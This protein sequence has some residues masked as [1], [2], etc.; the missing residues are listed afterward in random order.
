VQGWFISH[1][2]GLYHR[3]C[4]HHLT[5]A[6]LRAE[7]CIPFE[8]CSNELTNILKKHGDR[9]KQ[10]ERTTVPVIHRK[11]LEALTAAAKRK[12]MESHRKCAGFVHVMRFSPLY[13]S[14]VCPSVSPYI[15][16][17][18]NDADSQLN[19]VL[20]LSAFEALPKNK[21]AVVLVC[22]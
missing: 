9:T 14:P 2:K 3:L 4:C 19:Y 7:I 20:S 13:F 17:I 21:S 15:S 10:A 12:A 5:K 18:S 22:L 6:S 16:T 1:S 11:K 8:A